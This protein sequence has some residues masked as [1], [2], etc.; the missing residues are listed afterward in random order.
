MDLVAHLTSF[1]ATV[2]LMMDIAVALPFLAVP[3]LILLIVK[4]I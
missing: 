3:A 2:D 1:A 4:R